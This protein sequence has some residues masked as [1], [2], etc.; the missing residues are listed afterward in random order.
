MKEKKFKKER[1]FLY[2]NTIETEF[3]EVQ[4]FISFYAEISSTFEKYIR[5]VIFS[6]EDYGFPFK[7]RKKHSGR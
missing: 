2:E 4:S 1:L 5:I 6:N 3:K 7:V